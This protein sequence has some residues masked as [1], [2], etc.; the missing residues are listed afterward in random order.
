MWRDT[1]ASIILA[2]GL[3]P[4]IC[5]SGDRTGGLAGTASALAPV[6]DNRA[7]PRLLDSGSR[8]SQRPAYAARPR[9]SRCRPI[10]GGTSDLLPSVSVAKVAERY[11]QGKLRRLRRVETCPSENAFWLPP[12]GSHWHWDEAPGLII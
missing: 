12:S 2:I 7:Q 8:S 4:T 9:R 5:L 10:G 1:V 3:V 11:R 6:L